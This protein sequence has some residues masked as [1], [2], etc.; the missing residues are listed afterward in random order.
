M[1]SERI[2]A[3]KWS[4]DMDKKFDDLDKKFDHGIES[5]NKEKSWN[6]IEISINKLS[7]PNGQA[8]AI[9]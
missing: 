3:D 2:W 8:T 4:K 6:Q 1:T 7:K 9:E 5:W